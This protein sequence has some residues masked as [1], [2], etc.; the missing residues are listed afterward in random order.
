MN[1]QQKT[2]KGTA[3]IELAI[4]GFVLLWIAIGAYELG[5]AFLDR[6]AMANAAREGARAG[7]AAGDFSTP[8]D[9]A[10][11]LIIEA[12]AGGLQSISGNDLKELWI[13]KS[14][15]NGAVGTER[16]VYRPKAAGDTLDL[17][18]QGKDWHLATAGWP[19]ANRQLGSQQWLG[20]RLVVD[21]EW[22]TGFPPFWTGSAR[23]QEDVIMRL[24]P[25]PS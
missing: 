21:H 23:W 11:C 6:T 17:N 3:A 8:S 15:S 12:A 20:V 7:S 13:Y 10:D 25:T 4:T 22:K 2:D 18:C 1:R 9:N 14:N 24:E 19:V 5:T 16:Q